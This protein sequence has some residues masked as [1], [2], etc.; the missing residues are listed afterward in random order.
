MTEFWRM[1]SFEGHKG[2][3]KMRKNGTCLVFDPLL[4]VDA[5]NM[6]FM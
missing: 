2:T 1:P 4:A 3:I 6:R 5:K